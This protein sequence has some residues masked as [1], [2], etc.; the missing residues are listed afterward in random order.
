[1]G[2]DGEFWNAEL[3]VAFRL[4]SIR[5]VQDFDVGAAHGSRL[6]RDQRNA[7]RQDPAIQSR[8]RD[9][10][11]HVVQLNRD[12]AQYNVERHRFRLDVDRLRMRTLPTANATN[13]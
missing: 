2:T 9:A 3:S 5:F 1:M 13:L 10:Y 8:L 7:A 6:V 4:H 12:G 11:G